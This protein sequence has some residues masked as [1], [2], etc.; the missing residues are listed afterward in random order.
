MGISDA[1]S[2]CADH[3]SGTEDNSEITLLT[4]GFFSVYALEGLEIV[5]KDPKTTCTRSVHSAVG[6][7]LKEF[8]ISMKWLMFQTPLTCTGK[9]WPSVTIPA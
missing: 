5:V 4:P 9:S 2:R 3:G 7:S 1:L 8:S 6:P